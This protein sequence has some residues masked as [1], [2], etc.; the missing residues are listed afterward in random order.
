MR[1]LPIARRCTTLRDAGLQK[2]WAALPGP[3]CEL[4]DPVN[5]TIL[6]SVIWTNHR[7]RNS[8]VSGSAGQQ[9]R[10]LA[11]EHSF[12]P[13]QTHQSY[14]RLAKLILPGCRTLL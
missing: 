2:A 11:A 7:S 1:R 4:M 6:I 9:C 10:W 13:E 12:R 8:V 5:N 3:Q 14:W